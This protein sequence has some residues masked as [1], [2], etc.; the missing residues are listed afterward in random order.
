M[1]GPD[2]LQEQPKL[3]NIPLPVAQPVNRLAVNVLT[4]QLERLIESA[5]GGD[6][7]QVLIEDK[8]R[9]ADRI[10]NRLGERA[11]VIEVPDRLAVGERPDGY[12][13]GTLAVLRRLHGLP[14]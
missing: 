10:H 8:Q 4:V 7:A 13:R 6:D 11:R 9:I 1:P 14:S 3:W 2:I 12:R 5:V